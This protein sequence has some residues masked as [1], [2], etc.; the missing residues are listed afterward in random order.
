MP[1][2]HIER[3]KWLEHT[4][5]HEHELRLMPSIEMIEPDATPAEP[6]KREESLPL[7]GFSPELILQYVASRL[8]DFDDQIRG[9]ME[10]AQGRRAR[11]D[12]LHKFEEI[13]RSVTRHDTTGFPDDQRAAE[14]TRAC[15]ALRKSMKEL[16]DPELKSRVQNLIDQIEKTSKVDP[17]SAQQAL[18]YAKDE[19]SSLNSDNEITMMRL[20]SIVQLRSQVIGASSNMQASINESMKTV[21]G[22]M[23]A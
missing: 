13:V 8:R 12:E 4:R 17:G 10:E 11:A 22:N 9:F 3:D 20:N 14:N 15:Q 2:M 18:D 5:E 19:L 1:T 6:P 16:Q 7:L 23:R 21:I